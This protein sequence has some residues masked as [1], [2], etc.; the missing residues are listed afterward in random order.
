[1]RARPS[2]CCRTA[3]SPSAI[4]SSGPIWS[5]IASSGDADDRPHRRSRPRPCF[6]TRRRAAGGAFR[7]AA[8]HL[9]GARSASNRL[10]NALLS[11]GLARGDRLAVVLPQLPRI[12]RGRDC[13]RQVR[14]SSWCRMNYRFT[15][16]EYAFQLEDCGAGLLIYSERFADAVLPAAARHPGPPPRLSRTQRAGDLG[17]LEG[18]VQ[19]AASTRPDAAV[20]EE[21]MFYLGYTS[22]TTGLPR[23][24]W[25]PSATARWL[26]IIGRWSSAFAAATTSLHTGPFHHTAPFTFVLTQ[27]FMGGQVVILDHFDTDLVVRT[28]ERDRAPGAF[29]SRTCLIG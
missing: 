28:I 1:M 4:G 21:D 27:L 14:R 3:R 10:A 15:A 13:V 6:G 29:S 22:G 8:S 12:H 19:S 5:S 16:A 2:R 11:L 23:A 24:P 7:R 25:S 20:G 17:T 18:L 26:T 9:C